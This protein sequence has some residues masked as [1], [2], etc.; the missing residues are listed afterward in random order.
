MS[1]LRNAVQIRK[2]IQNN[3]RQKSKSN[4]DENPIKISGIVE[5]IF[6]FEKQQKDRG[7]QILTPIQMLQRLPIA[8]A[9]VKAGNIYENLLS[10]SIDYLY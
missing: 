3:R 9:Q 1:E 8:L 6:E 7:L 5:K 10:G 2:E 4:K